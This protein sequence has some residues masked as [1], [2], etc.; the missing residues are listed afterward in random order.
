MRSFVVSPRLRQP[1]L[2][3][4]LCVVALAG[5]AGAQTAPILERPAPQPTSEA[6]V[7]EGPASERR[8]FDGTEAS[9]DAMPAFKTLFTEIPNDFRRMFTRQNGAI[10]AIGFAGAAAGHAWDNRVAGT[11]WGDEETFE[12]GQVAG[13]VL[14]QS[15]GALATYAVGRLTNSPRLARVG[16]AIFRAQI[17]SQGTVQAIKF[18]AGRTRPDGSNSHSFPSGH[19]A[20][21]F[22]TATVIQKEYGWKAGIPAFAVAGFVASSR[23]QMRK[24]YLSDVIAGAT[25]GILAGRS[26]TVG[27]G[28]ARFSVDPMPVPGGMGVSFTRITRH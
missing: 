15:G 19:S 3:A 5:N 10:A 16:S 18:T 27:T 7:F 11:A 14:V 28:R 2:L 9:P 24:H 1:F 4:A 17:V 26:V 21:A 6:P 8:I 12:P 23:V 13:S 22:A 25:V 20:S